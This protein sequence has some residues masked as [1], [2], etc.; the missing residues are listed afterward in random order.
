MLDGVETEV[1]V[2]HQPCFLNEGEPMDKFTFVCTDVSTEKLI[3][4]SRVPSG[5]A[6]YEFARD[7]AQKTL[8]E[9]DVSA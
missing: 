9:A 7:L 3:A 6:L 8:D 1:K 4:N 5:Q 2:L